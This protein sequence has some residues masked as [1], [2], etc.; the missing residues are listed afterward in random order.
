MNSANYPP[1]LY[2]P[3]QLIKEEI[4]Y[5]KISQRELSKLTGVAT[6][7]I[8]EVLKGK[9]NCTPGFAVK[10]EEALKLDAKVLLRLQMNYD[11]AKTKIN[12]IKRI[13]SLSII[14]EK[15]KK[16]LVNALI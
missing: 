10:L 7:I 12:T 14:T 3:G 1:H 5:R 15:E 9:R 2:H 11:I 8:N 4:D 16:N 6:N 13:N